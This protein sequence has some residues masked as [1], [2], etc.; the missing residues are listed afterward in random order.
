MIKMILD[1]LSNLNWII[2]I[3]SFACGWIWSDL[4][5]AKK[6]IIELSARVHIL[7]IK[8]N[9][10]SGYI[11]DRLFDMDNFIRSYIDR[12]EIDK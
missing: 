7:D 8:L 10:K 5:I 3:P 9:A 1:I 11:D 2:L 12:T 4:R 6:E